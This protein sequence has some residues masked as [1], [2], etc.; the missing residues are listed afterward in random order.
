MFGFEAANVLKSCFPSTST[1]SNTDI[2]LNYTAAPYVLSL[3]A[4]EAAKVLLNRMLVA[5]PARRLGRVSFKLSKKVRRC[6]ECVTMDRHRL[7]FAFSR[8]AH[9]LAPVTHCFDHGCALEEICG[10]CASSFGDATGEV[11]MG[12]RLREHINECRNCHS[13]VGRPLEIPQSPGYL[14]FCALLDAVPKVTSPLLRPKE[15]SALLEHCFFEGTRHGV[16]LCQAFADFWNVERLEDAA[17]LCGSTAADIR[18]SLD[19]GRLPNNFYAIIA[20]VSFA[21]HYMRSRGC[22]YVGDFTPLLQLTLIDRSDPIVAK[23]EQPAR[24]WGLNRAAVLGLAAGNAITTFQETGHQAVHISTFIASLSTELGQQVLHRRELAPE[25]A[26]LSKRV[27]VEGRKL[28]LSPFALSMIIDGAPRHDLIRGGCSE[29]KLARL[30]SVLENKD[31]AELLLRRHC[32]PPWSR[33]TP[34]AFSAIRERQRAKILSELNPESG[35]SPSGRTALTRICQKSVNWCIARDSTWFDSV[36]PVIDITSPWNDKDASADSLREAIDEVRR[37]RYRLQGDLYKRHTSLHKWFM[38]FH[39]EDLVKLL[40]TRLPRRPIQ[41][42]P[43]DELGMATRDAD[44]IAIQNALTT[45]AEGTS[46]VPSTLHPRGAV[47]KLAINA[48]ER[49]IVGDAEWLD[50]VAPRH[51]RRKTLVS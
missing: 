45:H 51:Y 4:P 37:G 30:F 8:V 33:E 50:S 21:V 18:R 26:K 3:Y 38:K 34:L 5:E 47:R 31:R 17:V 39:Y 2:T 35:E 42:H 1:L 13:L 10:H 44:R 46:G 43:T 27:H 9:Q 25:R 32:P 29:A 19:H 11:L 15:R 12:D 36:M 7:G 22:E 16:N 20:M 40:P 49:A 14:A 28:G 24:D 41:P 23:L 48:L 6:P